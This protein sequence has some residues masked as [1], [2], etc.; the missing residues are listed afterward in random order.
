MCPLEIGPVAS[1]QVGLKTLH[2]HASKV[3]YVLRWSSH[4]SDIT[5]GQHWGQHLSTQQ[6]PGERESQRTT[7]EAVATSSV[8][9]VAPERQ[10]RR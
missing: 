3:V 5:W 8:G 7:V 1:S 9:G 6:L 2:R 10:V 4:T